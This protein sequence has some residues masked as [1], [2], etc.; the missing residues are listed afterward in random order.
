M[1][2]QGAADAPLL[3]HKAVDDSSVAQMPAG[4]AGASVE[5]HYN[6]V[7]KDEAGRRSS[8]TSSDSES[9]LELDDIHTNY[10][11]VSNDEERGLREN[12]R[13]DHTGP[14][15]PEDIADRRASI[16]SLDM[17]QEAAK[18]GRRAFLKKAAINASL[19]LLWYMFS[20]CISVV[21]LDS[22]QIH[23]R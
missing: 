16:E 6:V 1:D 22:D 8:I 10:Q 17:W 4:R 21:S 18:M 9:D 15:R 13:E 12:A 20:I 2:H 5:P 23:V 14:M 3:S 7:D 11:R 19:I